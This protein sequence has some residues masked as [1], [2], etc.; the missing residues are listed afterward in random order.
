MLASTAGATYLSCFSVINPAKETVI[1]KY[2]DMQDIQI[3]IDIGVVKVATSVSKTV[4]VPKGSFSYT[5][6]C[7]SCTV[8]SSVADGSVTFTFTP[9]ST[10]EQTKKIFV[11]ESSSGKPAGVIEFTAKVDA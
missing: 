1:Q 3:K 8:V 11:Y 7:R 6:A 10:G 4:E 2:V 9:T 5:P